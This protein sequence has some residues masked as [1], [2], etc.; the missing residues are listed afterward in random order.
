MKKKKLQDGFFIEHVS[1]ENYDLSKIYRF[2]YENYTLTNK[3]SLFPDGM[4]CDDYDKKGIH[5][6][7]TKDDKIYGSARGMV[8]NSSQLEIAKY[9]NMVLLLDNF[10]CCEVS[11]LILAKQIR[12]GFYSLELFRY[13]LD[14]GNGVGA[15]FAFIFF[16]KGVLEEY[17]RRHGFTI[18][19]KT[20]IYENKQNPFY[21]L[22]HKFGIMQLK[23]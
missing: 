22:E 16:R 15:Q 1:N 14:Y 8:S 6:I 20:F 18:S 11:K 17:Y 2:R 21:G 23:Q 5:F 9:L 13:L 3:E 12:N 19:R 10:V 7:I 4:V